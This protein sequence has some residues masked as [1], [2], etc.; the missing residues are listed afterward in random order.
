M[1][2]QKF[3]EGDKKT[4]SKFVKLHSASLDQKFDEMFFETL[5]FWKQ[6]SHN[7][8]K[9]VGIL[10]KSFLISLWNLQNTSP[11]EHLEEKTQLVLRIFGL[12]TESLGQG[13]QN[14]NPPVRRN[15]LGNLFCEKILFFSSPEVGP[16]FHECGKKVSKNLSKLI[17]ANLDESFEEIV[18]ETL[19]FWN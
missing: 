3:Q 15:N 18:R 10:I 2:R 17:S 11:E 1:L 13:C 19:C 5:C 16:K 4:L 14:Y 6:F 8:T 12:S 7:K 9:T